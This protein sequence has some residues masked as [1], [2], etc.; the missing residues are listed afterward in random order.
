M[1]DLR[2]KHPQYRIS[3]AMIRR[4]NPLELG[5]PARRLLHGLIWVHQHLD[6]GRYPSVRCVLLRRVLWGKEARD[7]R[8]MRKAIEVLRGLGLFEHID[9][10]GRMLVYAWTPGAFADV[11]ADYTQGYGVFELERTL[12]CQS[13]YQFRIYELLQLNWH[14]QMPKFLLP[15]I[16]P[17]AVNGR[18]WADVRQSWIN[19]AACLS[20][21]LKHSLLVGVVKRVTTGDV[22]RVVVKIGNEHSQWRPGSLYGFDDQFGEEVDV[23]RIVGGI[24]GILNRAQVSAAQNRTII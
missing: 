4:I 3:A 14:K 17:I 13:E 6:R 16:N 7:L 5:I 21:H 1:Q 9:I 10:R 20:Y 12:V 19:A 23:I 2:D 22:V 18:K 15:G 11:E 24:I 8:E